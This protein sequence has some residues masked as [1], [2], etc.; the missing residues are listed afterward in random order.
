MKGMSTCTTS[1][2]KLPDSRASYIEREF[3]LVKELIDPIYGE[4]KLLTDVNNS[5]DIFCK[6]YI[7]DSSAEL[8]HT[9]SLLKK[10]LELKHPYLFGL[11]DYS[12][13]RHSNWCSTS[14]TVKAYYHYN[15]HSFSK[16]LEIRKACNKSFGDEEL[17]TLLFEQSEVLTYL[18]SSNFA[19]GDIRPGAIFLK[20]DD[21]AVSTALCER[22][23]TI[24]IKN[25]QLEHIHL[26]RNLY[27]SP[28][29]FTSLISRKSKFQFNQWKSDAFSFGLVLLEAATLSSVQGIYDK[30]NGLIHV[31]A[32][33]GLLGVMERKYPNSSWIVGVVRKL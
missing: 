33:D 25:C 2:S 17:A 13:Q 15:D 6:T 19:H 32:I 22:L 31:G 11:L 12:Y 9:V 1:Q 10:R 24:E 16:E 29:L 28:T 7:I 26:N 18:Q 14:Y 21:S 30:R 20:K 23:S 4:V 5:N 3:H 27:M 8:E